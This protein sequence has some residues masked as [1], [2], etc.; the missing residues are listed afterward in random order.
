[1]VED[2]LLAEMRALRDRVIGITDTALASRDGLIIRA[3]SADIDPDNL[4]ALAA[5]SLGLAQRMAAE[6]G[7]GTLRE[8]VTRSSGG[9]VAVYAVGSG[10]LLVVVAD[11]GL[12]SVRLERET[13]ATVESLEALLTRKA[14]GRPGT[15][16]AAGLV[17]S[18]S[19]DGSP[20][21]TDAGP[22]APGCRAPLQQGG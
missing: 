22:S 19:A 5:A 11:V 13:R 16:A 8:A 21:L 18:A 9:Y 2:V 12:D 3:D 20:A 4:A 7:K 14:P 1:V 6:V 10:A 17:L 15:Q